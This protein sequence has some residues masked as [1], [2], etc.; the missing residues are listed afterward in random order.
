MK[1]FAPDQVVRIGGAGNK[2]LHVIEGHA[3]TY[4]F[5]SP[6]CKKW[7]TCAPE[8]IL[9]SLG[10]KLTDILGNPLIYD[11]NENYTNQL[12][13]L[14]SHCA[15]DHADYCEKIPSDV[16]DRLLLNAKITA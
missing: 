2:V 6:G 3:H 1:A 9:H 12:G 16:K 11:V 8:A 7:D 4:V 15:S 10:G 14:A 13:I 5:P